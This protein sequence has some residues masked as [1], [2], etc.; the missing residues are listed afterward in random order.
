[1][2]DVHGI[3]YAYHSS[4]ALGDLTRNRTNASLPFAGRYRLID[5]ALSSLSNAGVRDVGVIMQRDFQSLLDHVAGGKAWDISRRRGGLRLLPPFGTN[6]VGEYAGTAEA[7][8]AVIDYVRRIPQEHIVLIPADVL[9]NVDLGAAIEQ[10]VKSGCGITAICTNR[11][12]TAVHYRLTQKA[13]GKVEK[14]LFRQQ[15]AGAGVAAMELYIV[16]KDTLLELLDHCE[17]EHR[18]HFHKDCLAHYL[19]QGGD[20]DVFMHEG[21]TVRIDSVADY[22]EASMAMLQA[23]PRADLFPADRPVRTKERSDV[24]TYYGETA[25]VENSLV[26]D[27]C[28][29]EGTVKNCVLF[30]GVRV[31][32][33]AVLENC[34]VMQDTVIGEGAAL[35]YIISDKNV[36]IAPYVT[37]TGGEKLPLVL[38]K[39]A[40]L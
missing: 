9:C 1:M 33:G 27:G 12:P 34:I 8:N 15:G 4:P 37:L 31:A 3:V 24:S 21:Y 28:F 18:F 36:E 2:T 32:P 10:H 22:Y 7:L 23:G 16:R 40:K 5:F 25:R 38:P 29:I 14:V 30:R 6:H 13:D 35:K 26:A 11:T 39:R 19:E 17:S 20:M